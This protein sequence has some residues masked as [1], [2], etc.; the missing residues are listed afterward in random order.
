MSLKQ[1][2]SVR[3]APVAWRR[4]WNAGQLTAVRVAARY[5]DIPVFRE[6]DSW[7]CEGMRKM[8]LDAVKKNG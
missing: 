5:T 8:F 1:E 3:A 7:F 2:P 6:V 4:K